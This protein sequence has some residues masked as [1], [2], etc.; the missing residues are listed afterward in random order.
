MNFNLYNLLS[1]LVP[2]F[3]IL[4]G[5]MYRLDLSQSSI[6]ALPA[7]A[8]AYVIGYLVNSISGWLEGIIYWTWG[9]EP[10][11]QFLKGK[12]CGRIRFNEVDELKGIITNGKDCSEKKIFEVSSR[13]VGQDEIISNMN[14]SY[15]FSRV[16]LVSSFIIYLI[17]LPEYIGVYLYHAFSISLIILFWYRSKER[18]YYYVKQV[19]VAAL[20]KNTKSHS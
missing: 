16:I 6:P 5:I 19:F 9:G 2:G 4:M 15:V 17:L 8:L 20:N 7:T 14:A 10:A 1:I 3:L 13:L 11:V 18:A 12:G